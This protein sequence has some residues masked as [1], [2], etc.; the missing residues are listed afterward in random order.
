MTGD[1]E[2]IPTPQVERGHYWSRAYNTKERACSFWHQVDEVLDAGGRTVLE[3][4]PGSGIVTDW[5]R[6]S[7]L[8]VTTLDMD[9][10][11]AADVHGSVTELPF[12]N[13]AFDV[14]LCSQVLEHMPWEAVR[15]ALPELGRVAAKAAVIS[16]PDSRPWAGIAS[17]LYY[18]WYI[19]HVRQRLPQGRVRI[20][21][22][23]L[24][25]RIRVRDA[26]FIALTPSSW[27]YGGK[28]W[29]L[30]R[31]PVPHGS[32]T[33]EPHAEHFWELGMDGYPP[34]RL[35]EAFAEAE[36]QVVKDYRVPEN[37]WHRFFVVQP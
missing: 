14:I 22:D 24:R 8:E 12:D 36:L 27:A 29:A 35:L 2:Y 28:V 20:V 18:G 30:K 23:I 21:R 17:P 19:E 26:A 10:S 34:D 7:G 4:G 3:I 6:R 15:A 25:R 31:P 33:V 9:P 32:W 13:D 11:L 1:D 16:V 5:L 37:P